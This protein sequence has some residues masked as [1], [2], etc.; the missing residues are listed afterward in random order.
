MSFTEYQ[1]NFILK[2]NENVGK[3][4][5]YITKNNPS[6]DNCLTH[7]DYINFYEDQQIYDVIFIYSLAFDGYIV[8]Y[9][10]LACID[11]CKDRD[12]KGFEQVVQTSSV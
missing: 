6:G 12:E 8:F 10:V 3:I 9:I 7:N 11:C 2:E 4:N 5:T 1:R